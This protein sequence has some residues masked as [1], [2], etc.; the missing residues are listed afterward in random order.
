MVNFEAV[1][2][3]NLEQTIAAQK[4][5]RQINEQ[6]AALAL[7]RT[8]QEQSM[9]E[10]VKANLK[11]YAENIPSL[12]DY[13]N[14]DTTEQHT[15]QIAVEVLDSS[16]TSIISRSRIDAMYLRP[17]TVSDQVFERAADASQ[18]SASEHVTIVQRP[19]IDHA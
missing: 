11:D 2:R 6:R 15:N 13:I 8:N 5:C 18:S 4:L 12:Q 9:S 3:A 1:H 14:Q 16:K 10:E 19:T 17:A 7:L